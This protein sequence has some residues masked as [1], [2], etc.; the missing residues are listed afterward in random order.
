MI[1]KSWVVETFGGF[2]NN[3]GA[4]IAEFFYY[5]FYFVAINI[6][7]KDTLEAFKAVF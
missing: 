4:D 7:L 2:F 1:F 6:L 3:K 5:F